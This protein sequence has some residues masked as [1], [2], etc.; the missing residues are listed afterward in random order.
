[1]AKGNLL[2]ELQG[3]NVYRVGP[4]Y[5]VALNPEQEFFSEGRAEEL[6]SALIKVKALRV[7]GARPP[8]SATW[9]TRIA[10][11]R[12]C[13]RIKSPARRRGGEGGLQIRVT[14]QLIKANGA[15]WRLLLT[16]IHNTRTGG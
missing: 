11:P 15:L 8:S 6:T 7:V 10:R 3:R 2:S 12:P 13:A 14:R 4:A 1:M 16:Y 5:V 9:R